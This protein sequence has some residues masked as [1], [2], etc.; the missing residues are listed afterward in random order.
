MGSVLLAAPAR[1]QS[2]K[3]VRHTGDDLLLGVMLSMASITKSTPPPRCSSAYRDG[4][5]HGGIERASG[6]MPDA[7][8]CRVHLPYTRVRPQ[9]MSGDSRRSP[10]GNAIDE[11]YPPTPADKGLTRPERRPQIHDG[12]SA[13]PE[14]SKPIARRHDSPEKYSSCCH[15][16]LHPF[17]PRASRISE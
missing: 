2:A 9:A 14:H 11:P 7:L 15:L 1:R 8:F 5:R 13:L 17:Q 12:N 16:H 3:S 10:D 6:F 4:R